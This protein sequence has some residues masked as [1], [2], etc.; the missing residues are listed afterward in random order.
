MERKSI[1]TAMIFGIIVICQPAF[2]A[3]GT[4]LITATKTGSNVNG[5]AKFNETPAG[6]EIEVKDTNVTPGKHGF[7]IHEKVD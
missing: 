4:A 7:H 2:A 6:L 3:K 1:L 5:E